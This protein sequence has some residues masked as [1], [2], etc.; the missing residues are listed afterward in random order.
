[1]AFR[2]GQEPACGRQL[3]PLKIPV[4][5][6]QQIRR[7]LCRLQ[8]AI[9]A[10]VRA[11]QGQGSARLSRVAAVTA[12]DTIYAVDRV[13]EEAVLGWLA[14][15]WPRRWPVEVVMEGL[16]GRGPVVFPDGVAV[17][18]TQFKCIIDPIDGTR[19]LMYDKRSAW[20]LA[21]V[22]R[23]RGEKT[24]LEDILVAAMT[25]LP[26]SKAGAADQLSAV[27]GQGVVAER[28]DG[29]TG[30]KR[31][32]QPRPSTAREVAHGFASFVKFFPAGKAWLAKL[33]EELWRELNAGTEIFDDQYLSTGG[34]LYELLMG[35]DR[36]IAD[37]RPLAI[38][39]LRLRSALACHP[40]DLC[41]ALVAREAGCVVTGAD[42]GPLCAPLDTTSPVAWVGYA[43][44]GLARR[45]GPALR[46][47]LKA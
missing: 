38:T 42:G 8:I 24:G 22:A 36:F 30:R 33:E 21:G 19:G 15:N 37:L 6:L 46:R 44:V 16:E 31:R 43:N 13:S 4:R 7:L 5:Q 41:T 40:Y 26:T 25:E 17:G 27:R 29:R 32:F 9:R 18:D 2:A 12:A 20:S 14:R 45:I 1:M 28:M 3:S 47:V 10:A 39:R 23:Q 35:R 34:Q 11:T